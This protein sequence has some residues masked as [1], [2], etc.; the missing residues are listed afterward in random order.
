MA[1]LSDPPENLVPENAGLVFEG[2]EY[3]RWKMKDRPH[4]ND[5]NMT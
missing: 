2:P 3:T 4:K 1:T 5:D